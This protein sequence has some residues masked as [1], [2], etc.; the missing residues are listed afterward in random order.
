MTMRYPSK[1]DPECRPLFRAMNALPGIET[2]ESC[3]GHEKEP[4]QMWFVARSL[5]AL[6]RL[7]YFIDV[8]HVGFNWDCRVRT[9]CAM[10][11]V[12][13]WLQSREV[14]PPAYRQADKIAAA[15]VSEGKR[16]KP[17]ARG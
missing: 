2:I 11:P 7:L 1:L 14:G 8:C 17:A 9:D 4:F 5:R 12:V 15:L 10:S 6:P 3:C 13:F 16:R